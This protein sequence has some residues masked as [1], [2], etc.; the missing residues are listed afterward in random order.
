MVTRCLKDIFT[1]YKKPLIMFNIIVFSYMLLL[2]DCTITA[3]TKNN[4][5]KL[6]YNGLVWVALDHHTINIYH[7][8]DT[9]MK[10]LSIQKTPT[11]K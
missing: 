5:Y 7:S 11:Q 10:W 6:E 1:T 2:W 9:P 4:T 3:S 8:S